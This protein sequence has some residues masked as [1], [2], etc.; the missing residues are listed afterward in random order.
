MTRTDFNN[1]VMKISRKLYVQAYHFLGDQSAS[2]D[3]VQEVF[4]KLWKIRD[5]LDSYNSVEALAN[6]MTRNYCID[7]IRKQRF[8]DKS[9]ESAFGLFLADEPSPHEVMERSEI[10][11]IIGSII[12]SLPEAYREV[13]RLRDIEGFSYE[14][15]TEKTR[16]N[17]NTLRVNLSRGRK[18]VR[19]EF[20]KYSNENRGNQGAAGKVL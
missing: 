7:Q 9:G 6:T 4:V 2:E 20:I 19:D 10:W 18:M 3:A 1:L 14:E 16:L 15:I 17:I 5:S 12:D 8:I 11:S 13:L